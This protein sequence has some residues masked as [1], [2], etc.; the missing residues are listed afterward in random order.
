MT[1]NRGRI[2]GKELYHPTVP[3]RDIPPNTSSGVL[4]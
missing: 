3:H 4:S 1:G 2:S